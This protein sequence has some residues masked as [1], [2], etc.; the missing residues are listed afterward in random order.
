MKFGTKVMV[1]K[2][3]HSMESVIGEVL[4]DGEGNMAGMVKVGMFVPVSPD[5]NE[6]Q[7]WWFNEAEIARQYQLETV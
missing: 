4:R 3:G 5:K 2:R 1:T 7:T 6:W